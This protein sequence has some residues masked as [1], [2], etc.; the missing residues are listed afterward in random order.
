MSDWVY[1]IM[2]AREW[3]EIQTCS[4][5]QPDE[6]EKDGFIHLSCLHQVVEV[7]NFICAGRTDMLLL[8]LDVAH[9]QD[10]RSED[11]YGYQQ[12]FPH[13]YG[14]LPL[15]AVQQVHPLIWKENTFVLP[16]TSPVP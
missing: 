3:Q 7:A 6:L 14:P 8:Q 5:Y 4:A 15:Q 16:E 10:L 2:P 9:L 12:D 1:R 11:L 13:L